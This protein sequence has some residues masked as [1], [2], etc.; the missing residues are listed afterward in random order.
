M[1][2]SRRSSSSCPVPSRILR[3]V[4]NWARRI[5]VDR[6]TSMVGLLLNIIA[7]GAWL[8]VATILDWDWSLGTVELYP[9][10]NEFGSEAIRWSICL[11]G[12]LLMFIGCGD[13]NW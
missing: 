12:L 9:A 7:A 1:T 6:G 4:A 8:A 13:L 11:I 2:L 3:T 5:L 10:E